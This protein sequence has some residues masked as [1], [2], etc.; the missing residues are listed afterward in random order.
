MMPITTDL[1]DLFVTAANAGAKN[2]MLPEESREKYEQLRSD[3]KSEINAIFYSTPL[4][5]A[6]KA[7]G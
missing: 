6:R 4:D 1:Y 3:I 7:L 5:A 2:I